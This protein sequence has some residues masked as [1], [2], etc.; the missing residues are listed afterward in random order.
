MEGKCSAL[1]G[2][3][4]TGQQPKHEASPA[5][6]VPTPSPG[7]NALSWPCPGEQKGPSLSP[8]CDPQRRHSP[9]GPGRRGLLTDPQDTGRP[10]RPPRCPPPHPHLPRPRGPRCLPQ[11]LRLATP[12]AFPGPLHV[13]CRPRCVSPA[14]GSAVGRQQVFR[15]TS[16]GGAAAGLP[17]DAGAPSRG[18][19][20]SLSSV[21]RG[22][23]ATGPPLRLRRLTRSLLR[24]GKSRRTWSGQTIG[25][26]NTPGAGFPRNICEFC[27]A[28]VINT[29]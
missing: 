29:K 9:W 21:D 2:V 24:G 19:Q 26:K 4:A 20:R 12:P 16:P 13:C 10:P 17:M 14:P 28:G 25:S 22:L 6:R 27:P 7:G 18:A 8:L 3:W 23:G 5:L 1:R 15:K 11:P